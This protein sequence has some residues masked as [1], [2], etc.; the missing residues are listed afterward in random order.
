M[1]CLGLH[2]QSGHQKSEAADGAVQ[3]P[4]CDLALGPGDAWRRPARWRRTPLP[5]DQ[6]D[7]PGAQVEVRCAGFT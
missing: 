5:V 4:V 3:H 6:E 1:A 7:T 2:A